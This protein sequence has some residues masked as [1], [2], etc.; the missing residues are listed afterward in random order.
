MQ[1]GLSLSRA[2]SEGDAKDLC[3]MQAQGSAMVCR[4]RY[5][6]QSDNM[7]DRWLYSPYVYVKRRN[8]LLLWAL[9]FVVA[10]YMSRVSNFLVT[11]VT[12]VMS[13][14]RLPQWHQCP[15]MLT[16]E[17][18]HAVFASLDMIRASIT[19]M[20]KWRFEPQFAQPPDRM[21]PRRKTLKR[22]RCVVCLSYSPGPVK[23]G[24]QTSCALKVI[25]PPRLTQSKRQT[26]I[27]IS[28]QAIIHDGHKCPAQR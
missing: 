15:H 16:V 9:G 26:T 19:S 4:W 27:A 28:D 7:H 18:A 10:N 17:M 25:L 14:Q 21:T 20:W 8:S 2:Q 22:P 12:E 6:I 5:F 24:R 13:V 11:K 23:K 1:E 3:S